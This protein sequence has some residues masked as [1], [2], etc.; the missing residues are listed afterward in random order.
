EHSSYLGGSANDLINGVAVDKAGNVYLTGST[1]SADFPATSEAGTCFGVGKGAVSSVL[2]DAYRR[3]KSVFRPSSSMIAA[4]LAP[5]LGSA[6]YSTC[7]GE[8]RGR[9][10]ALARSGEFVILGDTSSS[11][12]PT[13]PSAIQPKLKGNQDLVVVKFSPP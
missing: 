5:H 12:F 4:K 8:S 10:L 6:V 13:T 9:A 7:I 1:A 3:A 2:R 11:D